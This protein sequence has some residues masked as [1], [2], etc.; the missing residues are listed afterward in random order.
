M[1]FTKDRK[2]DFAMSGTVSALI[3]Q[4]FEKSFEM[5]IDNR[6]AVRL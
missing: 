2:G 5:G 1:G 6:L 4:K 3:R